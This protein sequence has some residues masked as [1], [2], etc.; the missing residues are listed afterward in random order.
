M[1]QYEGRM[2]LHIKEQQKEQKNNKEDVR[3]YTVKKI[4]GLLARV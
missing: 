2:R 1:A 4:L 3:M